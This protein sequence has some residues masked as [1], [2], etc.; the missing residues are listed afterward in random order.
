M[1]R[2]LNSSLTVLVCLTLCAAMTMGCKKDAEEPEPEETAGSEIPEPEPEF[3]VEPVEEPCVLETVYFEFDSSELDGSAR[4]AIQSAVDC[5]RNQ[6]PDVRI[7]LTGACDPRGTEEYNIALGERRAQSVRG[8]MT[9]LGMGGGQI[10]VTS[11]GEEMAT[12]TD[13]AGWARDRNVSGSEN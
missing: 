8:Y 7:L 2:H 4:S 9:S 11:V 12:G 13:E 10:S 3:E 6:N 1:K 5:Y